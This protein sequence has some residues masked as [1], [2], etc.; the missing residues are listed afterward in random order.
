[1]PATG[2]PLTPEQLTAL[3]AFL[4]SVALPIIKDRAVWGTGTLFKIGGEGFLITAA[5]VVRASGAKGIHVPRDE[6]GIVLVPLAGAHAFVHEIAPHDADCAV[7]HLE[8]TTVEALSGRPFLTLENVLSAEPEAGTTLL[9]CGYPTALNPHGVRPAD[10]FQTEPYEGVVES[11]DI[12]EVA[13]PIPAHPGLHLFMRHTLDVFR[14]GSARQERG[15]LL[16]GISGCSVW[17]PIDAPE[18]GVWTADRLVRVV[19]VESGYIQGRWIR[20]T[21]WGQVARMIHDQVPAARHDI[22]A[23]FGRPDDWLRLEESGRMGGS[24]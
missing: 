3:S 8:P 21:Y 17:L 10:I 9:L 15:P 22:E 6:A 4:R 1:M 18:S 5:H 19:A 7:L 14:P 16:N 13:A 12:E 23:V 11:F 20:A 24:A 2:H